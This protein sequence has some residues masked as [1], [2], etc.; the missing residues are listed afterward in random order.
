MRRNIP[1]QP[2]NQAQIVNFLK[3]VSTATRGLE[4]VPEELLDKLPLGIANHIVEIE[5]LLARLS[6]EAEAH[7]WRAGH[8][9]D[10]YPELKKRGGE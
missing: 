1:S 5:D 6:A 8:G 7:L 4:S 3:S 9:P 10:L 2:T